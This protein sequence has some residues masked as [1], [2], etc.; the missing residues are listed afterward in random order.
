MSVGAGARRA[1]QIGGG[2]LAVKTAQLILDASIKLFN[3]EGEIV[4][5]GSCQIGG[6]LSTNAGSDGRTIEI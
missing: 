1:A 6:N 5:E 2:H 3:A 4:A